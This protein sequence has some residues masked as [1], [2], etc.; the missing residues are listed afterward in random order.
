MF[1]ILNGNYDKGVV[2]I[3]NNKVKVKDC[4]LTINSKISE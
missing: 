2:S 1:L 4:F 3:K